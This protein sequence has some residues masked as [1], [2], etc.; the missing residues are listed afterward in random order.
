ML[1]YKGIA[2][3]ESD[4]KNPRFSFCPSSPSYLPLPPALLP[5]LLRLFFPSLSVLLHTSLLLL[6]DLLASLSLT[7]RGKGYG[8]LLPSY[9]AS[10]FPPGEMALPLSPGV[11]L[12]TPQGAG[13]PDLAE[14]P[15]VQSTALSLLPFLRGWEARP[16]A[17]PAADEEA[18]TPGAS[19]ETWKKIRVGVE[20]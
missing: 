17:A 14:P 20:V 2:R 10:A 7:T 8:R 16:R 12:P 1:G 4:L 5:L 9:A 11:S 3:G 18:S 15:A 19:S 13:R 6:T